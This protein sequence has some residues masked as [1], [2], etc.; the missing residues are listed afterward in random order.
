VV[1]NHVKVKVV[2]NKLAP[3]FRVAI[4][5]ITYGTGISKTGELVDLGVDHD[6]VDKSGSWYAYNGSK[7][8]QGRE[9]AKQFF[10]DNPEIADEVEAK[11]KA[12][13]TGKP[14]EEPKQEP[15]PVK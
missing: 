1:G 11:I 13:V 12:K 4:F 8:A 7:I 10:E 14:I 3:P 6:I 9:A 2:K 5:D 15:A